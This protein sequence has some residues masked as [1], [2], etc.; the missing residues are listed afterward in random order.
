MGCSTANPRRRFRAV[1]E[2][3]VLENVHFETWD[4]FGLGWKNTYTSVHMIEPRYMPVIA[5]P[6]PWTSGTDGKIR[7]P[8]VLIDI[9]A[10]KSETELEDYRNNVRNSIIFTAPERCS[11]AD[12]DELAKTLIDAPRSGFDTNEYFNADTKSQTLSR[13][14]IMQILREEGAAV[15]VSPGNDGDDGTVYV[16]DWPLR[17]RDSAKP[18][19]MVTIAAEHCNRIVRILQK[20]IPV[21]MEIKIKSTFYDENLEDFNVVVE[22]PGTDFADELVIL[23]GHFDATSAGTG[24]TDNGAGSSVVI[25]ARSGY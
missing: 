8:V 1:S 13:T 5:Y 23:G 19:S 16:Y 10:M 18:L 14:R 22:I 21:E 24:A 6:N 4:E 3:F 2:E 11:N 20:D 7:A 15:F 17:K 9:G 25:E 12:L